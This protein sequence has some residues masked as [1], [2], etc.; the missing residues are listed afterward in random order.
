MGFM[1]CVESFGAYYD[2][3]FYEFMYIYVYSGPKENKI[4][5]GVKV[6]KKNKKKREKKRKEK[7][8]VAIKRTILHHL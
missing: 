8:R 2:D 3:W 5:L 1:Y 4:H 6:D 7:K